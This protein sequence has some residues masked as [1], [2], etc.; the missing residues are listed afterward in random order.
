MDTVG[1]SPIPEAEVYGP[2]V[3]QVIAGCQ[4]AA[5]FKQWTLG[6]FLLYVVVTLN[7]R[8]LKSFHARWHTNVWYMC[9][10]M[11]HTRKRVGAHTPAQSTCGGQNRM[12]GVFYSFPAYSLETVSLP[13]FAASGRQ[14]GQQA[15]GIFLSLASHQC[16]SYRYMQLCLLE[17]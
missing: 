7:I 14:A 13:K 5:S 12:L 8:C 2:T 1:S 11:V 15:L 10:L 17:I 3:H 4:C 6:L 9:V 16:W